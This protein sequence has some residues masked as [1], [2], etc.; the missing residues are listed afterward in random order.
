M[1]GVDSMKALEVN[2]TQDD[3]DTICFL[4]RLG[5]YDISYPKPYLKT[6]ELECFS[7]LELN[8]FDMGHYNLVIL[9]GTNDLI[10]WL[11]NL[12]VA[13]RLKPRQYQQAYEYIAKHIW[14]YNKPVVFAGHSLGGGLAV[15]LA[16]CFNSQCVVY[17]PCGNA[18]L[19]SKSKRENVKAVNIVTSRDILNNITSHIPFAK[20]YMQRVGKTYVVED[21]GFFPISIKSH[22]NFIALGNFKLHNEVE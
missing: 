19:L 2:L 12:K 9:C 14:N 10:D 22:S 8:V 6:H 20:F 15:Y 11:A 1:K 4:T 3:Y 5:Y 18:H 17:N 16:S 7:G 21:K 13:F